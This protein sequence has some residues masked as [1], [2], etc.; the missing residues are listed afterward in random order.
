MTEECGA[1]FVPSAVVS[2]PSLW[3]LEFSWATRRCDWA[4]R[5]RQKWGWTGVRKKKMESSHQQ[6]RGRPKVQA[7]RAARLSQETAKW[8][9]IS[10][11]HRTPVGAEGRAGLRV[12]S[13]IIDCVPGASL[14]CVA[15][16][17]HLPACLSLAA[18]ATQCSQRTGPV[19]TITDQDGPVPPHLQ[20]G[21]ALG[22]PLIRM[23]PLWRRLAP[24]KKSAS[25]TACAR[26]N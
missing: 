24:T 3:Q 4:S 22:L 13:G 6:V 20:P 16:I 26:Q 12:R 5:L 9:P 11:L 10:T 21:P 8:A 25:V 17:L 14:P 23:G 15:R 1:R 7:K 19:M 18:F 2:I